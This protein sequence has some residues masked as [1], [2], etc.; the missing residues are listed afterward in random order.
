[1]AVAD[2]ERAQKES[3]VARTAL[4]QSEQ[5]FSGVFRTRDDAVIARVAAEETAFGEYVSRRR[6]NRHRFQ[7]RIGLR[8]RPPEPFADTRN[9]RGVAARLRR[10]GDVLV[11]FAATVA[12]AEHRVANVDQYVNIE[13]L[14]GDVHP[15]PKVQACG[16][17]QDSISAESA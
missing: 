10:G 16:R 15:A 9:A 3:R 1:G 14:G 4:P 11:D 5:D 2:P 7:E 6:R 17:F 12:V 13:L 8:V